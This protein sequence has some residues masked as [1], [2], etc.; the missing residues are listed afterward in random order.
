MEHLI[1]LA[2]VILFLVGLYFVVRWFK[3]EKPPQ[4]N[5]WPPAVNVPLEPDSGDGRV[6]PQD[7]GGGAGPKANP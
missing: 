5:E 6:H 1:P 3:R 2:W 7:T 4:K